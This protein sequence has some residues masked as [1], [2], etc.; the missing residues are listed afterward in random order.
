MH[1]LSTF[2]WWIHIASV[3]EWILAIFSVIRLSRIENASEWQWLALAMLPALISAM[4]ACIW[5]LFDNAIVL[6]GLVVFQASSTLIGNGA[7]A[8]AARQIW[9]TRQC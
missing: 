4:S 2:T 5:H 8:L 9:E 3:I 1:A 7:M 6:Q